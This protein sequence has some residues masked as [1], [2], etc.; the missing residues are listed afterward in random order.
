MT[1]WPAAR[2]RASLTRRQ[3]L[4]GV[5]TTD[6]D[7]GFVRR[8]A[9]AVRL[10]VRSFNCWGVCR[11]TMSSWSNA[12]HPGVAVTLEFGRGPSAATL[13]TTAAGVLSATRP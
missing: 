6:K 9:R 11:G 1:W 8:L 10:P 5:G 4:Y 7:M 13:R 2:P 12:R 3:P